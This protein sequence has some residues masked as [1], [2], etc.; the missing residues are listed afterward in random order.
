MILCGGYESKSLGDHYEIGFTRVIDAVRFCLEVQ[1]ELVSTKWPYALLSTKY[2][3][4]ESIGD[5]LPLYR[6]E[7]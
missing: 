7:F 1:E 6:G 2:A 5:G 4:E 3:E